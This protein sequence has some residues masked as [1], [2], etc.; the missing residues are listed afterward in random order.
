MNNS[1]DNQLTN[2]PVLDPLKPDR[3]IGWIPPAVISRNDAGLIIGNNY[4][5]NPDN[6]I[7]WRKM[8]KPEFLVPNKQIFEKR[9][10]PVPPSIE[11]LDDKE[12]LILLG[13]IKELAQC[14]G[15]TSVK[16]VVSS[17]TPEYVIAVCS[18]DWIANYETENR[19]ITFSAIGDA[20]PRNTTNFGQNFLGPIAENRAFVRCVRNFLKINIVSQ[21]EIGGT[22]AFE[23]DPASTLLKDTMEKY[24][25][26][27]AKVKEKLVAENVEGASL[28]QSIYDIPKF[29]QL[30]LIARIKTKVAEAQAEEKK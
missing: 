30:E 27:F 11:G 22:V 9:N 15:F 14:R 26:S 10:K 23:E 6:T 25:I 29:K 24:G 4:I 12:L 7:N 3:V 18:I 16:Y 17:P 13:G 19:P 28:F 2:A 21:E 1:P 5:F 20:H 8:I